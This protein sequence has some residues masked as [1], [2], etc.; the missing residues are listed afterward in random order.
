MKVAF[1]LFSKMQVQWKSAKSPIVSP[2]T[3]LQEC[4]EKAMLKSYGPGALSLPKSLIAFQ[5]SSLEKSFKL[6]ASSRLME[7]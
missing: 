3:A 4:L 7:S 2:L 1:G 6:E 5:P